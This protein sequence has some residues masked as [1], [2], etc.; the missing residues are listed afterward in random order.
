MRS[1]G[2]AATSHRASKQQKIDIYI[3]INYLCDEVS[4]HKNK[5]NVS[6]SMV[7]FPL[8]PCFNLSLPFNNC[9]KLY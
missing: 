4:T 1:D 7:R 6:K 3:E 9:I 5:I 8:N 2:E